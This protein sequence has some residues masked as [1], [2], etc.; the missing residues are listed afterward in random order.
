MDELDFLK[1]HWQKDQE[2]PKINKEQIQT[3]LYKSSSS[4][5]KWIFIISVIELIVGITLNVFLYF[6]VD[7]QQ[8]N[9]LDIFSN[10]IDVLSYIVIIYFIYA[11]FRSYRKIKNT[12]NTKDL[13]SDILN[14]RKTV[15][16]YIKFNIYL[17]IFA[18]SISSLS[19]IW[20]EDIM[21][22]SISHNILFFT[23]LTI[24]MAGF[25]WL[26]IKLVK[27]YY[28]AIYIRLIKKLDKNYEDLIKLEE[29]YQK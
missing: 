29:E 18:I 6:K 2:F 9:A 14:T 24:F 3:M 17:I 27:L 25:G 20:E 5:V 12:N 11:F 15:G 13:L 23:L 16:Y 4:L 7:E 1:Q 10:I 26:I 19:L 22:R 8:D 28:K 21:N